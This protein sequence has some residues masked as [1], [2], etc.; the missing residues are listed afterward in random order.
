[1]IYTMRVMRAVKMNILPWLRMRKPM[2]LQHFMRII[3][4]AKSTQRFLF[5]IYL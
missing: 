1:M 4:V 5:L 2:W 3:S